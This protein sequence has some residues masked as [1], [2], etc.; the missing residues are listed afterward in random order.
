MTEDEQER[1]EAN[2]TIHESGCL[3]THIPEDSYLPGYSFTTGLFQQFGHP[4]IVCFGLNM[5]T[6]QNLLNTLKDYVEDGEVFEVD[7]IYNN[8]L[9]KGFDITFVKVDPVFYKSYL[10]YTRWFYKSDDFPVMQLV[11]PDSNNR[12]PWAKNYQKQ[13]VFTQPLLDRNTDFFF[14]EERNRPIF[15]TENVLSKKEFVKYV[16]HDEEGDCFFTEEVDTDPETLI[17]VSLDSLVK[18][19]P[20]LNSIFYLPFNHEAIRSSQDAK[21]ETQES[22]A[23]E[24]DEEC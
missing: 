21:W 4:E 20:S 15:T 17:M 24:D 8:K 13:L 9:I 23:Y 16:V 11:W 2:D 22:E 5:D 18:I 19:D 14:Y 10:G 7:K 12:F 3:I 1:I 6:A